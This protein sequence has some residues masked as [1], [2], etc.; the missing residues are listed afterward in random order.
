MTSPELEVDVASHRASLGRTAAAV[1]SFLLVA[2]CSLGGPASA[3]RAEL[4]QRQDGGGGG[5]PPP[6]DSLDDLL[7]NTL[8]ARPGEEPRP[9]TE[10]V[11][12]GRVVRVEPGR[13]FRAEGDDAERGTETDFS[14]PR[15]QWRTVHA[16]VEVESVV[17]GNVSRDTVVVGLVMG[18]LEPA[19]EGLPAL[20]RVVL[21]LNRQPVFDYDASVYGIAHDG[22]LIGEMGED[23]Q[24]GFAA[25][26][27]E[28][29]DEL[30]SG[31]RTV[32]QLRDA[33][34]R[35]ERVVQLDATGVRVG[36]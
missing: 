16:V 5:A 9:L 28:E 7:E 6:F 4:E 34:D 32:E 24:L 35:P 13:G 18:D 29:E 8:Y 27:P 11:V 2:G 30:L 14:D 10:A 21:F 3:V 22:R 25:L 36:G 26:S 31:P 1:L 17:S 23:G 19:Q 15:A 33:A 12:V 20:G